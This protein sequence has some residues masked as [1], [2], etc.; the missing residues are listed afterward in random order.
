MLQNKV[1]QLFTDFGR[2]VGEVSALRSAAAGIQALFEEVFAQ[3]T[4]IT[5]KQM[6]LVV[7]QFST[8]FSEVRKEV[9]TLKGQITVTRSQN[10]PPSPSPSAST[11]SQKQAVAPSPATPQP[12]Q[13][14]PSVPNHQ[15]SSSP[16][17]PQPPSVKSIDSR[18]I[19]D[20][21]EIFG[22]FRKKEFS[23]L[24]R[25]SRDGFKAKE[26]YDRCDGHANTLTVIF[27]HEREYFR[28]F[29]AGE[30]GI[31]AVERRRK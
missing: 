20:F 13:S 23:V 17:A 24:W 7:E 2:L 5:Q 4:Q 8:K 26:F 15:S 18:I 25:G 30:M 12:S 11:P 19:S 31:S 3:Q 16:A 28:R 1:T 21:P 22:E 9:L 29:Y 10:Q 14:V 27:G 6:D